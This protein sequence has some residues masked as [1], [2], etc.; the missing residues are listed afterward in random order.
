[1]VD[2]SAGTFLGHARNE[3]DGSALASLGDTAVAV[4]GGLAWLCAS[5]S[6]HAVDAGPAYPE[7][8][9]NGSRT[10]VLL[11]PEFMN[12]R[13]VD[14]RLATLI[15]PARLGCGNSFRLAFLPQV[16]FELGEAPSMSRKAFPAAVPVS[17]GCSVARK[18]TRL[19]LSS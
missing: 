17:I 19:S 16:G 5:L 14:L 15:D 8:P 4:P 7:A 12:N 1:M 10:E 11:V 6:E 9:C 2:R 3:H 18:T 13:R